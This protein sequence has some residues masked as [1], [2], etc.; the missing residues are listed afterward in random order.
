MV[1]KKPKENIQK[2]PR[3]ETPQIFFF[4]KLETNRVRCETCKRDIQQ[5]D[6]LARMESGFIWAGQPHVV[7]PF[8]VSQI[9]D[10]LCVYKYYSRQYQNINI[11]MGSCSNGV[12]SILQVCY[13][14]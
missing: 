12:N 7:T 6:K 1:G 3:N 2:I 4:K 9:L 14:L 13:R 8:V 11:E 5:S 10:L